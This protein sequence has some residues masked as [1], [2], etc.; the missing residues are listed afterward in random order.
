MIT[1]K[2]KGVSGGIAFGKLVFLEPDRTVIPRRRA[3][4]MSKEF[5]RL[6]TALATAIQQLEELYALAL[7]EVGEKE[8]EIFQIHQMM[9]EDED[10]CD[11]IRHIVET[12]QV[13]AEYAVSVTA[14]NFAEMF[15][16]MDDPYLQGRA[17]DVRDISDRLIKVLLGGEVSESM[18]KEKAIVGAEDL[19]PS[20]T[21]RLDKTKAMGFVTLGGSQNSHTAILARTMNV[22]AVIKAKGLMNPEYQGQ[23]CIIDGFSG[24]VYLAPDQE[25]TARYEKKYAELQERK[26][27]LQELK[28]K[29]TI[30][31]SG[32]RVRLY[33]NI[34]SVSDVWLALQ[35]D[36][37]GI[38]LFR[39][40][41]IYLE[42][43]DYPTEQEQF[44]I[45]KQVAENMAGRP[46]V[47]RTLDIGAD[48]QAAY[49]GLAAEENPALGLRGIRICLTRK[50]LFKTQLRALYR[51]S[52]F[53]KVAIMFPM[54][55]SKEEVTDVMAIA[56]EV[57]A[58]LE[59][60]GIPYDSGVE[61]GIMIETPAA[62]LISDELAPEVDFFSIGTNDLTQYTLAVDRQNHELD[63]FFNPHHP[64]ILKMIRMVA[65][66]A[67]A[68]GKWVGICGELGADAELTGAFMEMGMDELSVSP[69]RILGLR[70]KI[71]KCT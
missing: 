67:H 22:P 39:T 45:Y 62:A 69:P 50:E 51:A 52:S 19:S 9:L 59:R 7:D 40:E 53:G 35:N 70:D 2:G 34:G 30:T 56:K 26:R 20:Q 65:D 61:L 1:L 14:D 21:L 18:L 32:H 46:V 49:F 57:R 29:E 71:R 13:N 43:N 12:Q 66:N 8:A 68:H 58:E 55:T 10:Y 17:A 36:A 27:L 47:F 31:L 11:S 3:E 54:I 23:E 5:Q 25:T 15:T 33:A 16:R 37:E 24:E 44:A 42:S 28:G 48:K 6:E 4:S 41:F 38:G 60:Q 64:A 63:S